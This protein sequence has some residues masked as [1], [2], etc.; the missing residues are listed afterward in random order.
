MKHL[1]G[2]A[3]LA[4]ALGAGWWVQQL[5]ERPP[6]AFTTPQQGAFAR[7]Q[8]TL[9]D[10]STGRPRSIEEWNGKKIV[11]N[12][13]ASWCAPCLEELPLFVRLQTRYQAAGVQF[14]GVAVDAPVTAR[15]LA[16][17]LKLNYPNLV[18]E[19]D[20]MDVAR[21]L[22]NTRGVLPYTVLIGADGIVQAQHAGVV[23]GAALEK[24]LS[25]K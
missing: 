7:P 2:I 14:V 4:A 9:A 18:G 11:L 19:L 8:F 15:P 20:A 12:F 21:Q 23:N 17:R 5:V 16:Q 22:G 13:W 10:L 1:L 25:A 3:M 24:W 6:A